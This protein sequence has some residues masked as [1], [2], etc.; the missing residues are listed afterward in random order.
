MVLL[1]K[2]VSRTS[3]IHGEPL[4]LEKAF[5]S[6]RFGNRLSDGRCAGNGVAIKTT[7]LAGG[8]HH[9]FKAMLPAAR[10]GL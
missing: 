1:L 4:T 6:H 8:M 2:S 7:G 9:A 10:H 3:H 5:M